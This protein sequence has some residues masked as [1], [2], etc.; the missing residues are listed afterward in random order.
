MKDLFRRLCACCKQ[1]IDEVE[2]IIAILTPLVTR[3]WVEAIDTAL[4][5]GELIIESDPSLRLREL[6][7]VRSGVLDRSQSLDEVETALATAFLEVLRRRVESLP[8]EV[9]EAA[10]EGRD[11]LWLGALLALGIPRSEITTARLTL[12]ER[13]LGPLRAAIVQDLSNL[14]AG[15]ATTRIPQVRGAFL[16][17]SRAVRASR[18]PPDRS[19]PGPLLPSPEEAKRQLRTILGAEKPGNWIPAALDLWGYRAWSIFQSA[20][21]LSTGASFL[22][23]VAILDSR[24]TPFCRWVNRKIIPSEKARSQIERFVRAAAAGQP[25]QEIWPLLSG[26]VVGFKGAGADIMFA[27]QFRGL[28]LPPYHWRCRTG[29]RAFEL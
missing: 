23:L 15:R 2:L 5:Q 11:E 17:W 26:E 9:L 24:T 3:W 27:Q 12:L 16:R 7:Q 18:L 13:D 1:D 4:R 14:A 29:V 20:E 25:T 28:G 10:E 21:V 19:A 8:V 6:S 22:Q